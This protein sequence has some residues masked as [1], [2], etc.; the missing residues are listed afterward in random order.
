MLCE[1]LNKLDYTIFDKVKAKIQT[2]PKRMNGMPNQSS[3]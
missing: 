2:V 1:N 3:T